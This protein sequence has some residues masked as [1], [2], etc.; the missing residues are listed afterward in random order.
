M[1]TVELAMIQEVL[2]LDDVEPGRVVNR[3][4]HSPFLSW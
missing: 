2:F 3:V 4:T 1:C